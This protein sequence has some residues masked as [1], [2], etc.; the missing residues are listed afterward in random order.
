[1]GTNTLLDDI[2]TYPVLDFLQ[3]K[4]ALTIKGEDRE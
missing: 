3:T 4:A 1:M 2:T